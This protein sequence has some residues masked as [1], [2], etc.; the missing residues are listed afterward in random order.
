MSPRREFFDEP[1][2]RVETLKARFPRTCPVCGSPATKIMR[3]KIARGT[4][5]TDPAYSLSVRR[6]VGPQHPEMQ[7]LRV[8]VCEDH[9]NPDAG[10][11][12]YQTLCILVDGLLV[13]FLVFGLLFIGDSFWRRRPMSI[14]P[15]L[16]IGLFGLAMI[17]T[18]VAFM[19]NA[20][21]KAVRIVGFDAGMQNVLIAFKSPMYRNEFMQ[22][23][24]MTAELVSWI[25]KAGS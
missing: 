25:L 10:T 9:A 2:V 1:V 5:F 15:F 7:V 4:E 23:N 14:W 22:E 16:I 18:K 12:R 6:K 19:P 24:Q 11:D 8:Q 17:L 13:G 21:A 3:M 20:V